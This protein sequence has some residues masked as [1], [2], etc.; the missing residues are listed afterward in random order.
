MNASQPDENTSLTL[1]VA[2]FGLTGGQLHR[3]RLLIE[4]GSRAELNKFLTVYLP[5]VH[6]IA[7]QYTMHDAQLAEYILAGNVGLLVALERVNSKHD[8]GGFYAA[9]TND[10][11]TA[12][13]AHIEQRHQVE[14][15]PYLFLATSAASESKKGVEV[16]LVR[17][18]KRRC[19]LLP[20][21]LIT[22]ID[23]SSVNTLDEVN[24]TLRKL[25]NGDIFRVSFFRAGAEHTTFLN[26]EDENMIFE[27]PKVGNI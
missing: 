13:H 23:G 16:L 26:C 19:I 24:T 2:K 27:N 7:R 14:R 17:A 22:Q 4:K 5:L 1:S 10:V 25:S 20:N 11:R 3:T 15:V 21:D 6:L 18:S 8:V 12:I 9:L